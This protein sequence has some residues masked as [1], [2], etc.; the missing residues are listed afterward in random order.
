MK[1]AFLTIAT[2]KYITYIN[3]LAESLDTFAKH[4]DITLFVFANRPIEYQPNKIKIKTHYITHTP[5][6]L[7]TLLRYHFYME[8]KEELKQYDYLFHIDCDMKLVSDVG[9]EILGDRVCV[10]HPGYY[11][12]EDVKSYDYDRTPASAAYVSY[13]DP[14]PIPKTFYQNCFQGGKSGEFITMS[15]QIIEAANHDLR[16]NHIARWHDE[17][18]MNK[19][20][21]YNPPTVLLH[22]GY[23]YPEKWNIPFTKK[24]VHLDK[25]HLE[26]R[27]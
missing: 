2:N 17:S 7:G 11:E 12:R 26:M 9:N 18:Y 27:K 1:I 23:A 5:H 24:I 22:S 14:R 6:P 3:G 13:D 4:D 19:Y 20:M 10:N 21:L 25:N 15:E 8:K 16:N